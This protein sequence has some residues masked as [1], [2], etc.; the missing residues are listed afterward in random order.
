MKPANLIPANDFCRHHHI[1]VNFLQ[2]LNEYGLIT[3]TSMEESLYLDADEL[4]EIE[5]MMRLHY[6]LN[7]NFEGIDA[8]T[9]LLKRMENLQHEMLQLRARLNVM[10]P[11][12]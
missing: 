10:D 9:Q 11:A 7:I 4:C 2:S 12:I 8:I 3:I 1:E 5:K 6:D